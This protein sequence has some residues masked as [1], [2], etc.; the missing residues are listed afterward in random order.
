MLPAVIEEIKRT[1]I[2]MAINTLAAACYTV[3][4]RILHFL[5]CLGANYV[6]AASSHVIPHLCELEQTFSPPPCGCMRRSCRL[7]Q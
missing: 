3:R 4:T 5:L 1:P 6:S 2:F 7:L